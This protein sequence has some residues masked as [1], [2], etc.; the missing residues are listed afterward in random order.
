[1]QNV[2]YK[3][4]IPRKQ[5]IREY[6]TAVS[7]CAVLL[8]MELAEVKIVK[9]VNNKEIFIDIRKFNTDDLHTIGNMID[10]IGV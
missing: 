5:V 9:Y 8:G 2:S 3:L 1:M 4:I 10:I 7:V 6:S